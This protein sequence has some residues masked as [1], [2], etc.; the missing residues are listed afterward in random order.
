MPALHGYVSIRLLLRAALLLASVALP[1]RAEAQDSEPPRRFCTMG[2]PA[3]ACDRLL[4]ASFSYYPRFQR[5]S[6]IEAPYEWEVGVLENRGSTE[7]V[8]LT[9]VLGADGEGFRTAVKGRYRRWAGRYAA[10]DVAGGV[11][12]ARRETTPQSSTNDPAVGFTGDMAV[13]LTDWASVGVRGD[14]LWSHIDRGPAAA[15]YGTVRLGTM[16]GIVAGV[17]AIVALGLTAGVS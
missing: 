3:P 5:F 15:T 14:L 1:G 16:P 17:L 4:F 11:A 10:L 13:G 9:V 2:R 12:M 8:G 6:D 7:A